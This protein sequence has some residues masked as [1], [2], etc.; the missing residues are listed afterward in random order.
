MSDRLLSV[1]GAT[2]L[3]YVD[4]KAVGE[5]FE[6]ESVGVVNVTADREN[7][8][9]VRLQLELDNLAEEHLP[10]HMDEFELTPDQ[11]RALAA[12][13]EKHPTRVEDA[14]ETE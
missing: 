1:T 6:W 11:A 5:S 10:T 13:L 9:S 12:G 4:G 2:T 8:D 7:P 3:D 14:A